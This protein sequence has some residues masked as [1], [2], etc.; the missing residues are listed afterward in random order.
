MT[1]LAFR[2]DRYI[3]C[4]ALAYAILAIERRPKR[5]QEYNDMQDMRMLLME[6]SGEPDFYLEGARRHIDEISYKT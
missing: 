4:K 1:S 5:W 6:L 3:T 2:R